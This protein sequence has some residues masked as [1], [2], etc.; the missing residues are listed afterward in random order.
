MKETFAG[1]VIRMDGEQ[2]EEGGGEG[3]LSGGKEDPVRVESSD[4]VENRNR[5]ASRRVS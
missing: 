1:S 3:C 2:G 4:G 5:G